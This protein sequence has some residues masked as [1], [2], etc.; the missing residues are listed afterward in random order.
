VQNSVKGGN[1]FFN[2]YLYKWHICQFTGFETL[3]DA[4]MALQLQCT[5]VRYLEF[6]LCIPM[7]NMF[8]ERN[9]E[10]EKA[11]TICVCLLMTLDAFKRFLSQTYCNVDVDVELCGYTTESIL[12]C[13]RCRSNAKQKI[14]NLPHASTCKV[15]HSVLPE[16]NDTINYEIVSRGVDFCATA[17]S[18]VSLGDMAYDD[19]SSHGGNFDGVVGDIDAT[20]EGIVD[21]NVVAQMFDAAFSLAKVGASGVLNMPP[22]V[23]HN[24]EIGSAL[25]YLKLPFIDSSTG[26]VVLSD[27]D[28]INAIQ[29]RLS[30]LLSFLFLAF[31]FG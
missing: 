13:S 19:I 23:T 2:Y 29:V 5:V 22:S 10:R 20:V 1:T 4:C 17:I 31:R 25:S 9:T 3:D 27:V 21:V 14:S 24:A 8:L 15:L 28:R 7:L 18:L 11:D 6:V 26:G 30:V 16:C 12:S